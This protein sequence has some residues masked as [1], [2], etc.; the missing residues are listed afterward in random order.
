MKKQFPMIPPLMATRLLLF[1]VLLLPLRS[2]A[3]VAANVSIELVPKITVRGENGTMQRVEWSPT[4]GAGTVWQ[5]L[6]NVTLASDS[7]MVVD[8]AVGSAARFYRT[9]QT[10]GGGGSE[11]PGIRPAG[12]VWLSPGQFTMGSP[13][14]EMDRASDEGPQTQVT[15]S[16][17]F[18]MGKHEVTQGEYLAVMGSNPSNFKG[19]NN[20]P[21]ETV[22]WND[23]I[24]YCAKLT[25]LERAAG[26]LPAG[27]VYRLP[28]EAEWEYAARTGTTTRFSYGDDTGYIK[29]GD[30]AWYFGNGA[31]TTHSVGQKLANAWGLYDMHGNVWESCLD[32]YGSYPGGSLT[33]PRGPATGSGR[34]I[35]GGGWLNGAGYCRA[36]FRD[37]G[38]TG[39]W[40]DFIGFRVVL[41]PGQ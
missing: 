19:D 35:R 15:L 1:L 9:V 13:A 7:M 38:D 31:D 20:R 39:D 27:Y 24:N 23:A 36:A 33:D 6:T 37:Y 12:F 2:L 21:V 40:R 34:V 4:L 8:L 17:G 10:S 28:T 18:L 22:S 5:V 29:L 32:W 25:E 3:V 26:R 30:Y 11:P 41:A 14:N 16:R